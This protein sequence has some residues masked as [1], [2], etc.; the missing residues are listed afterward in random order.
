MAQPQTLDAILQT[1]NKDKQNLPGILQTSSMTLVRNNR[2]SKA[3]TELKQK[4]G[5]DPNMIL[6]QFNPSLQVQYCRDVRRVHM[7]TAPS[8]ALLGKAYGRNISE[9]WL[10]IQIND[11]SEFAGVKE[12]LKPGQIAETAKRLA[13]L[14]GYWKLTEFMLF[15]SRFKNCQ[16]GKFWGA[17]DPMIIMEAAHEFQKERIT[18]IQ[19]YE[20]EIKSSEAAQWE[21]NLKQLRNRYSERVPKAWTKE[22]PID[23]FQYRLMGFD[24]MSDEALQKELELIMTGKKAL[25][26]DSAKIIELFRM[27]SKA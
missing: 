27:V 4:F 6:S 16:Y 14:Y 9:S 17:V 23:F 5:N 1:T 20:E 24:F 22:A 13:E 12:K 8:L 26:K 25:P 18:S 11:L 21:Q 19:R 10:E 2:I 7:G 15:F 3:I